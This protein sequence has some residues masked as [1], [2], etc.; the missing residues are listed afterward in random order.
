MIKLGNVPGINGDEAWMGVQAVKALHGDTTLSLRTPTGNL[1]NWFFFVPQLAAH[2]IAAPSFGL[3]RLPAVLSG[4]LALPVN[5]L[6]CRMVFGV[7]T[8]WISTILLAVLPVNIAYSR[9]AWDSCQTVLATTCVILPALQA[10]KEPRRRLRWLIRG[11]LG[12][13]AS[14]LVHPTN[15][16]VAPLLATSAIWGYWPDLRRWFQLRLGQAGRRAIM[17]AVA[18]GLV[19]TGFAVHSWE[20]RS[21]RIA[22]RLQVIRDKSS[23]PQQ[24]AVFVK[25]FP[26]LFTG[27]TV[28]QYLAGS[29]ADPVSLHLLAESRAEPYRTDYAPRPDVVGVLTHDLAGLVVFLLAALAV[30]QRLRRQHALVDR[31]L[32][33]GWG[34][35]VLSFYLAT[36]PRAIL[37]HH[38][39]YAICLVAPT[40]LLL[41]RAAEWL[42]GGSVV[43]ARAATTGLL[44]VAWLALA[45]FFGNY[46]AFIERTGGESHMTFRTAPVE[47]KA[48]ALAHIRSQRPA[49]RPAWIVSQEW[50]SFY[51]LEYLTSVDHEL[52]NVR[53]NT[54]RPS[55]PPEFLDSLREGRVWCVEFLE[56]PHH[57]ELKHWLE[58]Q[59]GQPIE[60]TI[61]RDSAG[62]PLLSIMHTRATQDGPTARASG[63]ASRE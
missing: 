55:P 9:F 21:E 33:V 25:Y 58:R 34:L 14:V 31:C 44:L 23:S 37:P 60:E 1:L 42:L 45:S 7:R 59:S 3:L 20:P 35:T 16:L 6:L 15:V 12:F 28:Y 47:P 39:R 13:V 4:V 57:S 38:E 26:R 27:V 46:F 49:G 11:G 30:V 18:A 48:A 52:H 54:L 40:A 10:V 63:D 19:G 2:A 22:N 41:A 8:A 36:E 53:A 51:P 62:R 56:S 43:A 61:L 50:W 5:F 32:V 17:V 29:C 24:L